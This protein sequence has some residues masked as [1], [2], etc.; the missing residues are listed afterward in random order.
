MKKSFLVLMLMAFLSVSEAQDCHLTLRGY[1][2]DKSTHEPMEL[3]IVGIPTLAKGA[4]ADSTGYFEIKNICPGAYHLQSEHLGC[5]PLKQF[6]VVRRDTFL[7]IVMDHHGEWLNEIVVDEDKNTQSATQQVIGQEIIRNNAQQSV[8]ELIR[9]V[10]GVNMLSNGTGIQKPVI[11]GL[12]GNRIAIIN[13]GVE[14]A[15]QQWGID[16]APEIDPNTLTRITVVK[17]SDAIQYGAHALGGVVVA[18]PG[19]IPDDPHLH[20]Y[21]GYVFETNGLGHTIMSA[22]SKSA[23]STAWRVTASLKKY[24]DRKTPDYFLTNTGWFETNGS[25]QFDW[26]PAGKTVHHFY[27]SLFRKELGIFAGAHISNLTDLEHAIES[28]TPD[29]A[30][31]NFSYAINAP[32]QKVDHHLWR[33]KGNHIKN[34][35]HAIEWSY[36]LQLNHR[37]EY[38]PRRGNRSDIPAL[39]LSLWSHSGELKWIF[40]KNKIQCKSGLQVQW[41]DNTN[42]YDTGILPLIPDYYEGEAGVF[43]IIQFPINS[44]QF[45]AGARYDFRLLHAWTISKTLPREIIE[46][47]HSYHNYAVTFGLVHGAGKSGSLKWNNALALRSPEVN[48]LYSNGLHQGVAGIEE[49][50]GSLKQE[51]S[52]KSVLTHTLHIPEVLHAEITGYIHWIRDYIYLQ[53]E[54][55]LRLTIR[56]AFPVFHY[57]QEDAVL[58][59]GEVS[60]FTDFSHRIEISGKA[61]AMKGTLSK[62]DKPLGFL[63]P[64]EISTRFTWTIKDSDR[65][66][67][68]RLSMEYAHVA[69]QK[70]YDPEAEL[71][72]PPDEYSLVGLRAETSRPLGQNYLHLGL[73]MDNLLDRSY[74]NYLNRLRYFADEMGRTVSISLR[75]EF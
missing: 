47:E 10:A 21:G 39:D 69:R 20:G 60:V 51:V 71:A 41:T 67:G 8:A 3:A 49:G 13:N 68:T 31:D 33:Y 59:G 42:S 27:Y 57:W 12:Y 18:E 50:N 29:K 30:L 1:V 58:R 19:R 63:P 17:G 52:V 26:K 25:F 62:E 4:V 23:L 40:E 66:K 38:D 15:G 28:G 9:D 64:A 16:H 53:P 55:S 22:V 54:D 37:R 32:G 44:W 43:S 73:R 65:W 6:I 74:R 34:E 70:R 2:L 75:Y 72:A 5:T 36:G 7:I 61:S 48:E 35:H 46:R 11:H 24:G 14:Q 45:E 56:G